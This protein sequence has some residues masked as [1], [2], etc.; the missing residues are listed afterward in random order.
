MKR[1]C[2]CFKIVETAE[3]IE[4]LAGARI[5]GERVDREVAAR[6]VLLP[7]VGEGDR[8]AAA[9]GRN[10]AAQG[11]DFERVAVADSGDRAMVDTGGD[12]LDLRRFQAPDD[13]VR[14]ETCGEID[15]AD[16]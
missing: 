14:L 12:S 1:M 2:R 7:V 5:G 3:I 16:R 10:V 6:G 13:L 11:R 8:R 4:D 9:I 15:V